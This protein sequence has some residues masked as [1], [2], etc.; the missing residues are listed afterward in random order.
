MMLSMMGAGIASVQYNPRII[1][2]WSG[3]LSSSTALFWGWAHFSGRLPEPPPEGVEP[4]EIEVHG[5][6]AV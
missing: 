5:E 4:K 2:A 1:G 3:L 6:P